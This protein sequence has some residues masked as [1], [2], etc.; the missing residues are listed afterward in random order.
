MGGL[1]PC[2]SIVGWVHKLM[3]WVK[4]NG[5]MSISGLVRRYHSVVRAGL[6]PSEEA[7]LHTVDLNR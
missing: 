5:P 7:L 2:V 6:S 1:G 4:K 3:G